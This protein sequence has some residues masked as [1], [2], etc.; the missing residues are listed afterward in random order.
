MYRLYRLFVIHTSW[1]Q[2]T[3]ESIVSKERD[4]ECSLHWKFVYAVP[5]EPDQQ[6]RVNTMGCVGMC[7]VGCREALYQTLY[8]QLCTAMT[9]DSDS[10]TFQSLYYM[11]I[12][13][14][15]VLVL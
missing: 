12:C 3:G 7:G 11:Y 8:R 15:S 4:Y 5:K 13:A 1:L 6:V 14:P 10:L 9:I 2:F